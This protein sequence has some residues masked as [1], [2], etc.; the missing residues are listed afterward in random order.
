[1]YNQWVNYAKDIFKGCQ[2]K[3]LVT[4]LHICHLACENKVSIVSITPGYRCV[5]VFIA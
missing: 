1:M 5:T 4:R 3:Q 2:V